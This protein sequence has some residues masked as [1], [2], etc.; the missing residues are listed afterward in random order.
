MRKFLLYMSCPKGQCEAEL[1]GTN[2]NFDVAINDFTESNTNPEEAEY[3][4]S[5]D[6]WKYRHIYNDLSN[7]VFNYEACAMFDDDVKVSTDELNKLFEIGIEHQF[8]IWQA[9]LTQDSYSSWKHLYQIPNSE[10]R[11][12]NTMEIMMPFFSKSALQKCWESFNINYSAW[13]LDIVWAYL[14]NTEKLAVIDAIPVKHVRPMRGYSRIMPNGK[15]PG[16]ECSMVLQHYGIK[17]PPT[18]Y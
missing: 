3:K 18:V 8:N 16:E 5:T 17:S 15:T 13:G 11:M 12:T 9:A 14:L 10:M 2:R 7:I 6:Q 1:F 4:F